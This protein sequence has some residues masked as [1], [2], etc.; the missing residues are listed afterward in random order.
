MNTCLE[1]ENPT[2]TA[3]LN[4]EFGEILKAEAL[5]EYGK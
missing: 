1:F 5:L 3:S 2:P 4:N